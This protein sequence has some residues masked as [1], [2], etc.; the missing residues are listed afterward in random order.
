[1]GLVGRC[2][3]AVF[4]YGLPAAQA[5]FES[6]RQGG[7]FQIN[8]NNSFAFADSKLNFVNT[9][10]GTDEIDADEC[11]ENLTA[12]YGI[13]DFLSPTTAG[14]DPLIVSD[15]HAF[16]LKTRQ[17]DIDCTGVAV[18]VAD[19]NIVIVAEVSWTWF[20]HGPTWCEPVGTC[21]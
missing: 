5:E 13:C 2:G 15:L 12:F 19:E 3:Q 21:L 17:F 8:L 14:T 9:V 7:G 10:F 4:Q 11:N 6:G 20:F 1:M 16:T 18:C